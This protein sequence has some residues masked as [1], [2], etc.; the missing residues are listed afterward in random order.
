[1]MKASH[2]LLLVLTV[3]V[4]ASFV[5]SVAALI[6]DD[7]C[8]IFWQCRVRSGRN[9]QYLVLIPPSCG[10]LTRTN[11]L[12]PPL[13]ASWIYCGVWFFFWICVGCVM[14]FRG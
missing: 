6:E 4:V 14:K 9:V 11:A 7:Y 2:L 1:M 5:P 13:Q 8:E 3:V 12:S 10:Q